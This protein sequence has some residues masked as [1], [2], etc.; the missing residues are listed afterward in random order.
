MNP[1]NVDCE[2]SLQSK[3]SKMGAR[4]LKSDVFGGK[5]MSLEGFRD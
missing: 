2:S 3:F 1:E 5:P 4:L